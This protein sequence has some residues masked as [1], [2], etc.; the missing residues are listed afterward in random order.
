M[1]GTFEIELTDSLDLDLSLVWDRIEKP[2]PNADGTVPK[3]D[4]YRF[5]VGV[6]YDF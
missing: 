3:Q 1:I 6:G 4:D 2:R 5:I